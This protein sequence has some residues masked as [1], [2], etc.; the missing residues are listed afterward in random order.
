MKK[1]IFR[2]IGIIVL[3][4]VAG[5]AY[6]MLTTKS[7]SPF[8]ETTASVQGTDITVGYCQPYKKGRLLF[9]DKSEDALLT[10]GEYW[11]LGANEATTISFS[12]D[13]N[14]A[15]KKLPAGDYIMYAV[16]GK[17]TWDV[18]IN[19]EVGRWGASEAD[20]DL[21]VIKATVP[22]SIGDTEVEQLTINFNEAG[23]TFEWG[24]TIVSIPI[25]K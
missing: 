3:V 24:K 23:M 11:R 6:V 7:H 5:V 20:H 2:A 22:A 4:I 1:N 21:D 15:G 14:F 12:A 9:G 19:T 10:Y 8:K 18:Y 17:D 25:S 16:P 13:V